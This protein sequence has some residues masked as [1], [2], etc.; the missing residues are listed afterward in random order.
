MQSVAVTHETAGISKLVKDGAGRARC[1]IAQALPF[2]CSV[3]RSPV[4]ARQLAATG[5]DTSS[6][7]GAAWPNGATGWSRPLLPFHSSDRPIPPPMVPPAMQSL[8][9][10][11][12]TELSVLKWPFGGF[13]VGWIFQPDAA[14]ADAAQQA[15]RAMIA[16]TVARRRSMARPPCGCGSP[17]AAAANHDIP[18]AKR[19]DR[20][21]MAG[22]VAAERLFQPPGAAGRGHLRV[23]DQRAV[24]RA[25]QP[26]A[27][28]PEVFLA[29]HGHPG[30]AEP[31]ADGG[32][33]GGREPD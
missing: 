4:V 31:A 25:C 32:D 23:D 11:Q 16:G 5:Q 28:R 26:V 33:V 18:A 7:A 29:A 6:S 1:S 9:E 2:Q 13:G 12:A 21:P 22:S 19:P 24:P 15:S 20:S 27:H 10:V 30:A 8:M 14:F 3:T 17:V